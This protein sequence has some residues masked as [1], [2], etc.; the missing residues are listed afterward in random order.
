MVLLK[1]FRVV[2]KQNQQIKLNKKFKLFLPAFNSFLFFADSQDDILRRGVK[3]KD[4]KI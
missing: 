4:N 2:L 1:D 3:P